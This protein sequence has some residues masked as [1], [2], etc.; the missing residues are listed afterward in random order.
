VDASKNGVVRLQ[1]TG[2]SGSVARDLT[3]TLKPD[4]FL[5]Y[6]YFTDLE[7]GDPARYLN[8]PA[9]VRYNDLKDNPYDKAENGPFATRYTFTV[10]P[11]RVAAQCSKYHHDARATVTYTSGT[12]YVTSQSL[13]DGVPNG[14]VSQPY[15]RQASATERITVSCLEIQFGG[16]DVVDG[17]AHSN[18]AL[19]IQGAVNF[20][21]RVET[22]WGP[23]AAV[24]QP[25]DG[26][27]WWGA[28]DV[29]TGNA[30]EY[31]P[32]Q[33]L[34][35]S[36]AQLLTAADPANAPDP[37]TG[38]GCVY[39]GQTT[40]RFAG[41]KMYVRS[42]GTSSSVPRCYD[43]ANRNNEQL[44]AKIPSL[45]YVDDG[46]CGTVTDIGYPMKDAS[47]VVESTSGWT[48][49]YH[50]SYGNAFVSGSLSGKVT[51]AARQDI[52][53]TGNLTYAG[54][55]TGTDALGLIPNGSAWVYHPVRPNGTNM[56]A[57]ANA[58]TR[59]DAAIL[60]VAHSFT[61]QNY[62]VGDAISS[63][64]SIKLSVFGV[65]AQKFRGPVGSF[66]EPVPNSANHGYLK[67]YQYDT[68]LLDNPPPFFLPPLGTSWRVK[69]VTD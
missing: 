26:K 58:V 30:P 14:P 6:I 61:V 8:D 52:V 4:G 57:P 25:T 39:K 43:T 9:H 68:R 20:T 29:S 53:V 50:C 64:T 27:L 62:K 54:G 44:V 48:P 65:I 11:E 1:A 51:V 32:V 24:P 55:R 56:L 41:D 34:P 37:N 63:S 33:Y 35:P 23:G 49:T 21:K 28:K 5:R 46:P 7:V 45:I 66:P 42:P 13:K 2:R 60:S 67:D 16:N 17:P 3:V 59:I 38:P 10:P 19:Q 36:N 18:D 69:Q 40:I 31:A 12:Y 47:G 15:T 22:S